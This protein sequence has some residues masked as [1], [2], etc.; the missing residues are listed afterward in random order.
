MTP[1]PPH[2]Q[3][4]C[5]LPILAFHF[6]NKR[7]VRCVVLFPSLE[8]NSGSCTHT[9]FLPGISCASVQPLYCYGAATSHNAFLQMETLTTTTT[10]P[11]A[12]KAVTVT[13]ELTCSG[14]PH[15]DLIQ[16]HRACCP[17][18]LTPVL[19]TQRQQEVCEKCEIKRTGGE[20]YL[21]NIYWHIEHKTL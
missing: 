3:E 13:D 9:A 8:E 2:S 4:L 16:C 12:N 21:L 18:V 14:S 15:W 1:P 10:E 5:P 11:R 7:C 17:V 19:H 6:K 20:P